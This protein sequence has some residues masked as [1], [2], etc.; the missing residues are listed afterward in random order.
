MHDVIV[1]LF[2]K[3][4]KNYYMSNAEVSVTEDPS[5]TTAYCTSD[6]DIIIPKHLL[7]EF[8]ANG[9]PRFTVFY[10]EL[11]HALFT[12]PLHNTLRKWKQITFKNMEYHDKYFH[13]INW[14]EDFFIEDKMIRTYPFLTDVMS[15]LKRCKYNYNIDD[16]DKA[17]NYYYLKNAVTPALSSIDALYFRSSITKLLSYRSSNTFGRGVISLVSAKSNETKYI[18]EIITFYN[19]CVSKGILPPDVNLP[20]LSSPIATVGQGNGQNG[21]GQSGAGQGNGKGSNKGGSRSAHSGQV[22]TIIETFPDIDPA[23]TT[24]FVDLFTS[25]EKM[26]ENELASRSKVE[27]KNESLDGLFN[28]T[29]SDS[30]IIQPR[31]TI[32]NFYNPNRLVDRV[33]FKSPNKVFANVSIY[34]DVSGST[35]GIFGLIDKVCAHLMKNI[36][37]TTNFYLYSSGEYSIVQVPYISWKNSNKQPLEYRN[38]PLVQQLQGGTNSDAIADVIMQQL[39]SKWLNIIVTDGDLD[40][41]MEKDNINSLLENVFVI[42]VCTALDVF[43][44]KVSASR[45]INIKNESD[46]ELLNAALNGMR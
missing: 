2:D 31:V 22:V 27:S 34:R 46:I 20:A 39:D 8:T 33:L 13:L 21:A 6:N 7:D 32:K 40:A 43:N 35:N 26:I 14:I 30:A 37:I 41:L 15:C 25:E 45:F 16:I 5:V 3:V 36:P 18:Q 24:I 28:A 44:G 11:G 1:S 29:Y 23:S 38:N 9:L 12:K 10:H 19:W 4:A 17:F 42:G